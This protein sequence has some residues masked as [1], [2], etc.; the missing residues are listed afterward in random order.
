MTT[1]IVKATQFWDS[2]KDGV[3]T[4]LGKDVW[5][6]HGQTLKKSNFHEVK[7]IEKCSETELK[8]VEPRLLQ[9]SADRL[10][11]IWALFEHSELKDWS[12][13]SRWA[14]LFIY[15]FFVSHVGKLESWKLFGT[16]IRVYACGKLVATQKDC[17][18]TT[19]WPIEFEV[20]RGGKLKARK[21][22]N[23][24]WLEV[25]WMWRWG[26][27]ILHGR[28]WEMLCPSERHRNETWYDMVNL[29]GRIFMLAHAA[30]CF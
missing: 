5:L 15:W 8:V 7:V 11:M 23:V 18:L 1:N 20:V 19:C 22:V 16:L 26:L 2:F 13:E 17:I 24:S 27:L 3:L 14:S 21:G 9:L 28:W 25:E 4:Q 6:D 12:L 30:N 10:E 29:H